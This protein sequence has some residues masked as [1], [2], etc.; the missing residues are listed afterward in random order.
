MN[1][2]A[3]PNLSH[4]ESDEISLTP[5]DEA[6]LSSA[7]TEPKVPPEAFKCMDLVPARYQHLFET[8]ND[9]YIARQ[10]LRELD[11]SLKNET[12]TEK[13]REW[14]N[15]ARDFLRSHVGVV[16]EAPFVEKSEEE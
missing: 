7:I 16:S 2:E 15:K 4:V 12:L 9:K 14:M 13:D 1:A 10:K 5:E 3:Q 8:V 6:E 11:S